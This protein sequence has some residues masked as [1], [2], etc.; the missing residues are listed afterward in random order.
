MMELLL[1]VDISSPARG[2]IV[3]EIFPATVVA[4]KHQV[5]CAWLCTFHGTDQLLHICPDAALWLRE[6]VY[7][8][9]LDA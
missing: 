6:I 2:M 9:I 7:I 5:T 1:Y 8:S 3:Q 4:L